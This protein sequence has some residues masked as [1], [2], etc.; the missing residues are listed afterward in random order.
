MKKTWSLVVVLLAGAALALTI[1]SRRQVQAAPAVSPTPAKAGQF[2]SAAGRVEPEGEEIKVGSE[3]D[4]KLARVVVDEGDSV[5]R[6]QV[7]AVLTNGDYQARVELAK[8]TVEER[9]ASLERLRNGARDEEKRESE[10]QL[11][12]AQ[13]QMQTALSERDRRQTLLDR[14]AIS[15]S[16]YDLTARD[17]ETARARVDAALQRLK[18]VRQQTRV[19]DIRRAEAELAQSEANVSE[20]QALLEK[21]LVRSPI[22][23]RVLRRYR[24]GGESVSGKGD[25]PIVSVGNL[26]RLRVRVDV[27]E[28]DVAKLHVGQQAWVTADAYNGRKFTGKVVRIGQALGRKNVRTDEPNERVDTKILET[29]VELDAGQQLPVGLRVDAF[30]EVQK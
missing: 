12:E 15:R 3:M 13:A 11:R 8:A 14:G 26:D 28:V 1:S 10:A 20:A 29:L 30:L 24:K 21:T 19:E 2:I 16:E 17:Y 27:D 25:T 6:G 7:L 23:G 18:L 4:G 5:R 9:R 22:D